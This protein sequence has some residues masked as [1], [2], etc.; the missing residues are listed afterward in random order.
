MGKVIIIAAIGKNLELGKQ[1]DLI[2]KI[3]E[4][5]QFFRKTTMGKSI[6]M[7]YNTFLSLPKVLPGRKNIV[8]THQEIE[9]PQEVEVYHDKEILLESI[10]KEELDTYIIGG[11]SIYK[12]FLL[13]A[14]TLLLTEIDA[15][16]PNA[17][18]YFPSF[19]EQFTESELLAEYEEGKIKYKRIKYQRGKNK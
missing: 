4:D 19:Q 2:W 13:D 9:L 15:V 14:E 5:L 1:N 3:K 11:A 12:Q 17:D 18:V 8:L 10:K 7:G 16:D 6:V